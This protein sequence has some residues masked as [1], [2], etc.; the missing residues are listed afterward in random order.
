MLAVAFLATSGL[1]P[2]AAA[3]TPAPKCVSAE[4]RQFDFWIGE[5]DVTDQSTGKTTA[6]NKVTS[7]HDGCVIRED[8]VNGPYTGA[9]MSFYFNSTGRWHQVWIDNQGA[10]L[11]IAGGL[12][13]GKMVL[14]SEANIKPVQRITWTPNPDGTVRQHWQTSA[15]GKEWT[16]AFDGLYRKRG[17]AA[18]G[19]SATE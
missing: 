10:P 5:W 2:P 16:T 18:S 15:D 19:K 11:F 7:D 13:D 4:Y 17:S 14:T 9:S 6:A 1:T 8:Y 12:Q 3:Q